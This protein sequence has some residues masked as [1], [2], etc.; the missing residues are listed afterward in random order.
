MP[1]ST[2]AT[3]ELAELLGVLS[4]PCRVQIVEQLQDTERNVNSLQELLGI[5]HSGVSQHLALLRTRKL[6]KERR[7]GRHVYYRLVDPSLA[8]WLKHGAAFLDQPSSDRFDSPILSNERP[9]TPEASV[10]PQTQVSP[11][12]SDHKPS[13]SGS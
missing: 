7:S 9:L 13:S 1:P 12:N 4:H 10:N 3:R 6:I 2:V 11:Q 8:E 5:S